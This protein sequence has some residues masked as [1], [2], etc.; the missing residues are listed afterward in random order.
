MEQE[1]LTSQSAS[2]PKAHTTR[3]SMSDSDNESMPFT[4]LRYGILNG[5]M[6]ECNLEEKSATRQSTSTPKAQT[7][8]LSML[9]Y[10]LKESPWEPPK[11]HAEKIID[12][13]S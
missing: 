6:E 11:K 13:I 9:D 4:A 2:T 3:P 10:N 7:R 5:L 12:N 1:S 8:H